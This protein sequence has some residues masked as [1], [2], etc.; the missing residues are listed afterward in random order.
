ME[1]LSSARGRLSIWIAVLLGAGALSALRFCVW[2]AVEGADLR[3]FARLTRIEGRGALPESW[4]ACFW[5]RDDERWCFEEKVWRSF[6]RSGPS[7][8]SSFPLTDQQQ[9]GRVSPEWKWIYSTPDQN[10]MGEK[11]A[12]RERVFRSHHFRAQDLSANSD[13]L[14]H[15]IREVRLVPLLGQIHRAVER[16][17]LRALDRIHSSVLRRLVVDARENPEFEQMVRVSGGVHVWVASGIHLYAFASGVFWV[18]RT[19]GFGRRFQFVFVFGGVC[20]FWLISGGRDGLL[21][22]WV[23]VSLR[24]WG[25]LRGGG[26]LGRWVPLVLAVGADLMI[27]W[28]WDEKWG[29]G[30][31]HYF[32]AVLGGMLGAALTGGQEEPAWKSH[33]RMSIYSWLFVVPLEVFHFGAQG[34]WIAAGTPLLSLVSVPILAQVIYPVFALIP[35]VPDGIWQDAVIGSGAGQLLEWVEK[36]VEKY[37]ALSVEWLREGVPLPGLAWMHLPFFAALVGALLAVLLRLGSQ[38][39]RIHQPVIGG[40]LLVNVLGASDA[41]IRA[42]PQSHSTDTMQARNGCYQILQRDVGQG[43]SLLAISSFG[44]SI[45][46]DTGSQKGSRLVPTLEQLIRN[47]VAQIDLL[48]LTHLD[49]DHAGKLISLLAWVRVDE[50]VFSSA[51]KSRAEKSGLLRELKKWGVKWR[52]IPAQRAPIEWMPGLAIMT[53]PEE[54]AIRSGR[55]GPA[56]AS[57]SGMLGVVFSCVQGERVYLAFGDARLRTEERWSKIAMEWLRQKNRLHSPRIFKATHHG[58]HAQNSMRS[59]KT[60]DPREIWVSVGSANSYGH[61]GWQFLGRMRQLAKGGGGLRVRRTDWEGDL[62]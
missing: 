5:V 27:A 53:E 52:A 11:V 50:V 31:E 6:L 16:L 29:L 46:I 13:P 20:A 57:N 4:R 49:E 43:D 55:L 1:C 44:Q 39:R 7:I 54:E 60:I 37:I 12:F 58:S 14:G 24:E 22:P 8:G 32:A 38:K 40:L 61:P 36:G 51:E 42:V 56:V 17:R 48:I 28:I 35:W 15:G 26:W 10:R 3:G 59:L 41:M 19:L 34:I 30:R 33:L 21:R 18:L 2:G 23:L 47:G 25:S 9:G 62:R 45:L